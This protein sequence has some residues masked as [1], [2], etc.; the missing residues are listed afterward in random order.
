MR[1]IIT[2]RRGS[3]FHRRSSAL[4]FFALPLEHVDD[5]VDRAEC[6]GAAAAR[7]AVDEHG[8]G[9]LFGFG[10]IGAGRLGWGCGGALDEVA[11]LDETEE[12]A[13][14]GGSAEVGPG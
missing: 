12:L 9:E 10:L 2:F 4:G 8:A 13:W 5:G 11:E 7:A 3:E 14:A 1:H 6:A